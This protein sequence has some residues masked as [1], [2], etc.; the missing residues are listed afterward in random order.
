MNHL[1]TIITTTTWKP[2]QM[3]VL[4]L[5][6][7]VLLI[8]R[9]SWVYALSISIFRQSY[10]RVYLYLQPGIW[11][12]VDSDDVC[13]VRRLINQWCNINI[14]QNGMTI[15]QLAFSKG[16]EN[17]IRVVSGIGPSMVMYTQAAL[18]R[19]LKLKLLKFRFGQYLDHSI[20]GP[21]ASNTSRI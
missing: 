20:Q 17:I 9:E 2:G 5:L 8:N 19:S 6:M 11:R 12:A 16:T 1:Q 18:L 14:V 10:F 7:N 15:L 13:T 21:S 3:M 4:N